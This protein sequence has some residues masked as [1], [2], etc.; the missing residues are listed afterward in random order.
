MIDQ[1]GRVL[2]RLPA[3]RSA[4]VPSGQESILT[5]PH[6]HA[7][8][9]K[10]VTA[11]FAGAFH[12]PK[13]VRDT[14]DNLRLSSPTLKFVDIFQSTEIMFWSRCTTS[15]R[16]C[17]CG[18][19]SATA[20]VE[21]EASTRC[22]RRLSEEACE[23]GYDAATF[24]KC[25]RPDGRWLLPNMW[26]PVRDKAS[27]L[28]NVISKAPQSGLPVFPDCMPSQRRPEFHRSE[29]GRRTCN[30]FDQTSISFSRKFASPKP[31]HLWR[32][33]LFRLGCG[34]LTARTTA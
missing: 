4:E 28:R 8:V 17:R 12:V 30:S 16:A 10:K 32:T 34:R 1:A 24:V 27:S 9:C 31:V 29:I 11:S 2:A 5:Q 15:T 7:A 19:I 25:C 33:L 14:S 26:L 20:R 6:I 21:P 23:C 13:R 18:P 22:P 3:V